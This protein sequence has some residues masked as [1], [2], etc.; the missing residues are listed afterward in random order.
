MCCT[1]AGQHAGAGA[2]EPVQAA[3]ARAHH[4]VDRVVLAQPHPLGA[5]PKAACLKQV[6]NCT[7]STLVA[8]L[9]VH[10]YWRGELHM[11]G[12]A[13]LRYTQW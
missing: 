2:G 13:Q 1:L 4:R 9:H 10:D 11:N 3:D 12:T 8:H 6:M 5:K 7:P